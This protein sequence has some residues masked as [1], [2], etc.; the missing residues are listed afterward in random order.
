MPYKK[1]ELKL[2][3]LMLDENKNVCRAVSLSLKKTRCSLL[4]ADSV[5][6]ALT[7]LE[8]GGSF[9][10][11]L[12]DFTT[13]NKGKQSLIANIQKKHSEI[14]IAVMSSDISV[15]NAVRVV[16]A[17]AFGYL[18]KPLT[19]N[20]FFHFLGHAQAFIQ[21]RREILKLNKK[22]TS[23]SGKKEGAIFATSKPIENEP[24][25]RTLEEVEKRHIL[26]LL[27]KEPNLERATRILGVTKATL[28]RRR[29]QYGLI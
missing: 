12:I 10:L 13:N 5:A 23:P 11:A 3:I 25:F 9:D 27:S 17:A 8:G 16:G 22:K 15:E 21:L 4:G 7:Y 29:K 19:K 1:S 6:Q 26:R 18:P 2:R 14:L 20:H 28:W 24:A